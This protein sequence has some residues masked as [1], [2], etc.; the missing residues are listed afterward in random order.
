MKSIAAGP[1]KVS[2][3]AA[4]SASMLTAQLC[5]RLEASGMPVAEMLTGHLGHRMAAFLARSKA[6]VPSYF[7]LGPNRNKQQHLQV[8]L[9]LCRR[10]GIEP[11]H[12]SMPQELKSCSSTSPSHPG[13]LIKSRIQDYIPKHVQSICSSRR[14]THA[15]KMMFP[16]RLTHSTKI[17]RRKNK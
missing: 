13:Q 11:L 12:V 15:T 8:C 3:P 14:P 16:R 10:G 6:S 1:A 5:W 17:N 9:H 2:G 7:G 4:A